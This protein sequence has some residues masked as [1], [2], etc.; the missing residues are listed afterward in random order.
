MNK[1]L[2][3]LWNSLIPGKTSLEMICEFNDM[4]ILPLF[5][6]FLTNF[7]VFLQK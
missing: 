1:Q 5:M 6:P 3:K 7:L 2:E 4:F